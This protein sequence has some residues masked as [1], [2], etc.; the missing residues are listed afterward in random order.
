MNMV[1]PKA[2]DKHELLFKPATEYS[3]KLES[4]SLN[5]FLKYFYGYRGTLQS[6]PVTTRLRSG[7]IL[8]SNIGLDSA[9]YKHFENKKKS[10]L[11]EHLEN[12]PRK[13]WD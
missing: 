6:V 11:G 3:F 9:T 7:R 4:K 2:V 10:I 1:T 13:I 5:G 8:G 12:V